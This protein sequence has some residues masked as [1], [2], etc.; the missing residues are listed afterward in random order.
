MCAKRSWLCC[1]L[2]I[3]FRVRG[4]IHSISRGARRVQLRVEHCSA[5]RTEL[6]ARAAHVL[7]FEL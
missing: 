5:A 1:E 2:E 3:C 4:A 7:A 6:S